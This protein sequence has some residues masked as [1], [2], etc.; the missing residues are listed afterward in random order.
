MNCLP[1]T[2]KRPAKGKIKRADNPMAIWTNEWYEKGQLPSLGESRSR[3]LETQ[4]DEYKVITGMPDTRR[5]MM[6]NRVRFFRVRFIYIP[7]P[8]CK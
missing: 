5:P 4:E 2:R 8:L 6:I 7:L 1:L 3:S